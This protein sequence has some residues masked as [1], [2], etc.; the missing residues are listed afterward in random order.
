M[1]TQVFAAL[2][3]CGLATVSAALADGHF[4][5]AER[6]ILLTAGEL[7]GSLASARPAGVDG[8]AG[9]LDPFDGVYSLD[10]VCAPIPPAR[11]RPREA[12]LPIWRRL[13]TER[14]QIDPGD[15]V[16]LV[17]PSVE[18]EPASSLAQL[19]ADAVIDTY[20]EGLTGYGPTTRALTPAV[21][22]RLDRLIHP[23]LVP[24][25]RPVSYSEWAVTPTAVPPDAL[26]KVLA[27]IDRSPE[28]LLDAEPGSVGIVLGQ[29]LA[30]R[31][32]LTVAEEH[33]LTLTLLR[34]ATRQHGV[35]RLVFAADPADATRADELAVLAAGLGLDVRVEL[36]RRPSQTW[37][38]H[39]GV[40][41][42][43]GCL[44]AEL[45]FAARLYELPVRSVGAERALDGLEPVVT[46]DRVPLV[47]SDQLYG[48][49]RGSLDVVELAVLVKAVTY[50][51]QPNAYRRFQFAAAEV[52]TADPTLLPRYLPMGRLLALGLTGAV[53]LRPASRM[54][55]RSVRR[56]AVAAAERI[57]RRLSSRR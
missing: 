5:D 23:D 48:D 13:L 43:G 55:P 28:W 41:F 17:L 20:A 4:P 2:S 44:A 56:R 57:D 7:T 36:G 38:S 27:L 46:G 6:R 37:L 8:P 40:G 30:A 11:W 32:L 16:R 15:D 49:R 1:S 21:G 39:P 52:A 14:W 53:G 10:E 54:V 42:V 3:T 22:A 9:L 24:G 34:D 35:T 50:A 51:M 12:E 26:R 31:G 47:L 33:E 45:A 19:F 29:Q 25:L 18:I